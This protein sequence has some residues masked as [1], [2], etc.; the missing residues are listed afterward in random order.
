MHNVLVVY[1]SHSGNTKKLAEQIAGLT[2]ADL[3]EL[4]PMQEYPRDY[5]TVVAQAKEDIRKGFSPAL[6][7]PIPPLDQYDTILVGTPNWWSTMA[8]PVKTFL[9]SCRLE[10]K[11]AAVFATHG[12]G[13]FGHIEKDFRALCSAAQVLGGYAAYGASFRKADIQNWLNRNQVPTV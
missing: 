3:L 7:T 13:G 8:P 1:Y 4:H 6:Q 2:G 5:N 12:G 9:Q 11:M 10:G